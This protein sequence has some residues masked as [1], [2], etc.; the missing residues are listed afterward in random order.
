MYRKLFLVLVIFALFSGCAHIEKSVKLASVEVRNKD[1]SV[2][3]AFS[4]TDI[5]TIKEYYV[6]GK[7]NKKKTPPGLAKKGQ[8]PPGL[9]KQLER[10]QKLPP[11]LEKRNLPSDLEKGLTPLPKGYVR[12][13]VGTD[14]VLM[15]QNTNVIVDIVYSVDS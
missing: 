2:K 11:G 4:E 10:N 8:L 3:V 12:L 9:Q 7:N 13:K 14:I 6:K 15:N 5:K 1:M